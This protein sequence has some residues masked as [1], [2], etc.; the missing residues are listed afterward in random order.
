MYTAE[1][2]PSLFL[3]VLRQNVDAFVQQDCKFNIVRL[4]F[5]NFGQLQDNPSPLNHSVIDA[6]FYNDDTLTVLLT[7]ERPEGCPV[8][9][10]VSL[11]TITMSPLMSTDKILSSLPIMEINGG[12]FIC[13][14]SFKRLERMNEATAL[15]VSGTRKVSCVLFANCRRVRIFEMDADEDDEDADGL[16]S[17][18]STGVTIDEED[19]RKSH[20]GLSKV[21]GRDANDPAVDAADDAEGMA[22][23]ELQESESHSDDD[24]ENTVMT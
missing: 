14:N 1:Q 11:K 13:A 19:N 7:E 2:C 9:T 16:A 15:A 10:Q 6:Q 20:S 4:R 24:K 18:I 8:M 12:L 3:T 22:D 23:A 17:F 21:V 5:N